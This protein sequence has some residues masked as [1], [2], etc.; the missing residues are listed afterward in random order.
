MHERFQYL[1][2][3]K[4]YFHLLFG[5]EPNSRLKIVFPEKAQEIVQ[6]DSNVA[7]KKFDISLKQKFC[8]MFSFL[9]LFSEF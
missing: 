8:K 3:L 2:V 9:P 4:Y 7:D 1:D 6:C 5:L